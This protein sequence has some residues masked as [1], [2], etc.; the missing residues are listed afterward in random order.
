MNCSVSAIKGETSLL[1][2]G[3]EGFNRDSAEE[4]DIP[5]PWP[6]SFAEKS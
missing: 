5:T 6:L 4:K 2:A 3:R 1:F